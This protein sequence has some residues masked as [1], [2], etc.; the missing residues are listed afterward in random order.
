MSEAFEKAL[1]AHRAGDFAAAERGYRALGQY[2]NALHNLAALY[3]ETGRLE[4]A[5]TTLRLILQHFADYAPAR[6]SLAMNLL[7]QRRYA[8][9]WA[10]YEA[11][12][13]VLDIPD[14]LA[15]CPEWRGEPL[16]GKRL[17]VVAEQGAGDQIMFGRYLAGLEAQGAEVVVACDPGSLGPLFEAAGYPTQAY[18][19]RSDRLPAADY[20][21]FFGSLPLRLGA[22]APPGPVWLPDLDSADGGGIGVVAR[23]SA[24]HPYDRH[25]SL[26]HAAAQSLP[27][28]G[29]DLAPEATGAKDFL[30]TA[31]IVAGLDLVI[32]V[33]TSIVHLAG[34][35]GRPCWVLLSQL[36]TDFRWSRSGPSDWYPDLRL[37]RQATPGDWDSVLREVREAL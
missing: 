13:E 11:R 25:R 17:A 20:W 29:R 9:G 34:S 32:A 14:P 21:C 8:E 36:G 35:M 5:E 1:A 22:G 6:H 33:D 19:R 3:N 37:F 7:A 26:P 12:R 18:A 27:A 28:L 30:E 16:S 4:D 15:D 23:G 10:L 2:R 31:T 24:I